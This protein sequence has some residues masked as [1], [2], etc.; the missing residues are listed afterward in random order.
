MVNPKYVKI[1]SPAM[2]IVEERGEVLQALSKGDRFGWENWHPDR[3]E[4]NKTGIRIDLKVI[5]LASG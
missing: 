1:G 2:R 4:S 3:P 5:K